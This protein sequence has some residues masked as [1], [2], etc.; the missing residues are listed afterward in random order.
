M[1]PPLVSVCMPC[2]NAAPWVG[3]ALDSVLAQTWERVEI[4]AVNDGSTDATG[5]VLE[6]YRARGVRVVHQPN[7]GQSAAANRALAEARGALIKFLDADDLLA[8]DMIARQMTRLAGRHDAVVLGEWARFRDDPA[9]A[10]FPPLPMYR[11]A[12]PVDWLVT[13]W[14][15]GEAMMQCALWLI[16]AE[17]LARSGGWDTSLSLINDFEF[18]TRVLLSAEEVLYSPHARLYYRSGVSGSV[19]ARRSNTAIDSAWRSLNLATQQLLRREDSGR[20]RRACADVLQGFEY[21]CYPDRLDL[22]AQARAAVARWG[23]SSLPPSGS[24]RYHALRALIGW[25]LASRVRRWAQERS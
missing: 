16:P 1:T 17:V 7:Q 11:D 24:P 12:D 23:G 8:P 15:T 14:S 9:E 19:S 3:A 20:T 18:F 2:H 4:V 25:R 13:E 22:C 5:D 6:Q 10:V 21:F